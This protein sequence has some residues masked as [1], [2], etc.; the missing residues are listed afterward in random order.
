MPDPLCSGKRMRLRNPAQIAAE[1][2]VN[3]SPNPQPQNAPPSLADEEGE[4]MSDDQ[5]SLLGPN[6]AEELRDLVEGGPNLEGLA[7]DDEIIRKL[8]SKLATSP[9]APSLDPVLASSVKDLWRKKPLDRGQLKAQFSQIQVPN[10]APFFRP[11]ATNKSIYSNCSEHTKSM[12]KLAQSVQMMVGD[13]AVSLAHQLDILKA[14]PKE[15]ISPEYR[16]AFSAIKGKG[17][18]ALISLAK[19]NA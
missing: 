5:V 7:D 1:K 16:T 15:A 9:E 12:D 8:R 13:A 2:W 6:A 4:V 19:C 18:D 11:Q 17:T 10:N 3:A 14:I